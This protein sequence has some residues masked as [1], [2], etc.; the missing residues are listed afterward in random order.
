VRGL[1]RFY[2][3]LALRFAEEGINAVAIDYFGRT[4]GV[5]KR[6]D[7]FDFMDHVRQTKIA[8]ISE[9][10]RAALD[11]LRSPEG[12][13]CRALFTV[14]F[15]FG[16]SNSWLQAAQGHGLAGAIGFYGRP[17]TGLTGEPGPIDSVAKF[18]CPILGLMGGADPMIPE[19]QVNEYRQALD[20]A[21]VKNEIISYPG[22]PHSF[23]DRAY[24]QFQEASADAWQ[25]VLAFVR[26]NAG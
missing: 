1:H 3:E 24:E 19:D 10:T 26:A 16:G 7:D 4:A 22:A 2:E 21:G 9:D 6:G 8:T 20:K 18:E 12:G 23:F 14:G 11:Y 13:S 17:G 5:A 15:C 25:R